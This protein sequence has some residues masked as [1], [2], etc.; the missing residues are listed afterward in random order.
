MRA[1]DSDE[2]DGSADEPRA[3]QLY[4]VRHGIA[5]ARGPEWPEDGQRPLTH[6]GAARM[7]E[8]ASGLRRLGA[9][10]DVVLTSPLLRAEQ[11]A[12]LLVAGLR[13]TPA[14][15][16][17]PALAPGE[18]PAAV[19]RALEPYMGDR[20]VALVGHEP[21]L[22]ALAAWLTGA[23]APL[24]FKKG[25]VCRIDLASLPPAA[26]GQ[27]VFHATPRMLRAVG[28]TVV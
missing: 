27:L 14:L 26:P 15:V 2:S 24:A 9:R 4:L 19:V 22:G 28:R 21:D 10:I 6:K 5:A 13:P 8:I 20:A 12:R 3:R 18:S 7:R 23:A 1:D 17:V 16:V 25:G 11:T